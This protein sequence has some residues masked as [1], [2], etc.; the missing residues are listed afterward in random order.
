ML[1]GQYIYSSVGIKCCWFHPL[2]PKPTLRQRLRARRTWAKPVRAETSHFDSINVP[3]RLLERYRPVTGTDVP[4]AD[5]VIATWWETA[6]WVNALSPYHGVKVH[7]IQHHETFDYLPK[8]RVAA[9][10]R[11]PFQK[12]VT[13]PW[14]EAVM[15]EEY[16]D[17]NTIVITQGIDRDLFHAPPRDM[18]AIPTFGFMYSPLYWKGCDVVLDAIALARQQLP[19]LRVVAFGSEDP[20]PALPL[21]PD[22]FFVKQPPQLTLRE[23]Y[24]QCDAWLF[25]SRAEGFALPPMEAMACRT[26]VIGTPAGGGVELIP[27]GGILVPMDD[28]PAM[29]RAMLTIAQMPNDTWRAL[30]DAAYEIIAP[31]T[32][33]RSTDQ[34]EA[35]LQLAVVR[36]NRSA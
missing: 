10:Y 1:I 31:Y 2:A 29:A 22:T 24:A 23:L 18:Q 21:P 35:A 3:R 11:L 8:M 12:I 14:L 19:Q 27:Q 16:Q 15:H 26:P 9:V 17:P 30:S 20:V 13:A 33:E 6:E 4:E 5:V 34:L 32:W 36:A 25:G 7:L 28:A